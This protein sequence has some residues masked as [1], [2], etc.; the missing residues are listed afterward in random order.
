MNMTLFEE[1]C[2]EREKQNLKHP[3]LPKYFLHPFVD[4]TPEQIKRS[5]L[6]QQE[7]NDGLELAGEHSWFGIDREEFYEKYADIKKD[8]DMTKEDWLKVRA[9]TIQS[10][11]IQFRM[12][13]HI[14]SILNGL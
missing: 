12:L 2:A 8:T 9:E 4:P 10:A 5:R 14:D 11:A 3:E 1:I 7:E 13:E 6:F